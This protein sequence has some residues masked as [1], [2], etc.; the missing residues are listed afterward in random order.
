MGSAKK[1]FISFSK[2]IKVHLYSNEKREEIETTCTEWMISMDRL[3]YWFE[4]SK[5]LLIC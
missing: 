2:R 1:S 4:S 3:R 5:P